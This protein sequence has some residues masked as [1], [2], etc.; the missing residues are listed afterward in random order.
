RRPRLIITYGA[1][2]T[3]KVAQASSLPFNSD[4]NWDGCATIT[5][6]LAASQLS[7]LHTGDYLAS[8]LIRHFRITL[9]H[10]PS[11]AIF[12]FH[13]SCLFPDRHFS[14]A[15]RIGRRTSYRWIR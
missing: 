5:G 7:S 1:R 10:D 12:D 13:V 4:R 14:E 3:N 11:A 6:G 2:S 8:C 9:R 15:D